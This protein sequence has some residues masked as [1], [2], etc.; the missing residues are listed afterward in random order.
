M[1][2]LEKRQGINFENA[3]VSAAKL[4]GVRIDRS[5]FLRSSLNHFCTEEQITIAIAESPAAAGISQDIINRLADEAIK[6]ETTRVSTI[7]V[8]AGIPGGFAML[9]TIPLDVAQYMGHILRITQKL[10]YLYSWPSLFSDTDEPDDATKGILALFVGV[11]FGVQ[12]ANKAIVQVSGLISEQIVRT[13]PSKALTQGVIYPVVKRVSAY[14]GVQMSKQIFA[15]GISKVVPIIGGLV[16]GGVTLA[17]FLPMAKRLKKHLAS[18]EMAKD[19]AAATKA[20]SKKATTQ[21]PQD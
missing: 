13:L 10:A 14:L 5:D 16:S 9:G 19:V 17:T 18:L 2:N 15:K 3:L 4:P 11:M 8:V 1:G 12:A 20:K 21:N 7:S 6:W